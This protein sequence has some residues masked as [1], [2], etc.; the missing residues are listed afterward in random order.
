M[1]PLTKAEI[2]RIRD[3]VQATDPDDD[4]LLLGMIEGETPAGEMLD[5]LLEMEATA[6]AHMEA[7]KKRIGQLADRNARLARKREAARAGMQALLE[8]AGLRKME[9]A[10]ATVSIRNVPPKVLGEDVT[11]L[12][13]DC[14]QVVYKPDKKAIKAKLE[15]GVALP[16]WALSNGGITIAINRS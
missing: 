4:D 14:V 6:E 15:A 12:P 5:E 10:A 3:T 13:E 9:R 1:H 11:E 2:E 8:A 16:G 7:N